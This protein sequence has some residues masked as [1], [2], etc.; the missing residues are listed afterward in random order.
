MYN[1]LLCL[2]FSIGVATAIPVCSVN[3][4]LVQAHHRVIGLCA[5]LRRANYI[6]HI[7]GSSGLK[8]KKRRREMQ[9]K[10][11]TADLIVA[12]DT[13]QLGE[14]VDAHTVLHKQANE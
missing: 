7:N 14:A 11:N 5:V 4:L 2:S 6:L 13:L 12:V 1:H 3:P 8:N 10:E 9:S